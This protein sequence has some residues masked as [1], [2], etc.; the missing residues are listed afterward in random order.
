MVQETNM[1]LALISDIH[2]N[3]Q[4]LDAC[5]AHARQQG[6]TQYA[7]L[8]DLVGYGADPAAVLDQ[9]MVLAAQGAWVLKGN[10]DEMALTPP[11]PAAEVTLGS[12][13]AQWTHEQL[14]PEHRDFLSDLPLTRSHE[15]MLLVHAS[16]DRP[17]AW[18]YVDGERAA[19]HC[20]DVAMAS[21]QG[22]HVFV[23]HVHHQTLYYQGAGRLLM[24]FEPQHGVPVP[25]SPHRP[26]VVCV[27]SC[28]QPRDGDPRAMYTLYDRGA[29]KLT[30]HR[31]AYN[32]AEAAAAIRRA[33]LPE[34]FAERLERGR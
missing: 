25:V 11:A 13:G 7:F 18:R 24:R 26:W 12:Q 1:R 20:L 31:V 28:G 17:E 22:A 14:T 21:Q 23:G 15:D 27:G 3:R 33:G 34:F 16:A 2:A 8:G 19:G 30:F 9:I 5:L 4:A 32:H 29:R 10:H 6:A